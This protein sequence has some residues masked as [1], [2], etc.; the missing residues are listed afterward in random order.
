MR[1]IGATGES[2]SGRQD[3]KPAPGW[4]LGG[5]AEWKSS[6]FQGSNGFGKWG[7]LGENVV[8]PTPWGLDEFKRLSSQTSLQV[9]SESPAQA[10][11]D[12]K[13]SPQ[14]QTLLKQRL[15][16]TNSKE[17]ALLSTILQPARAGAKYALFGPF[18]TFPVP[19]THPRPQDAS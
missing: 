6:I 18:H 14:G 11:N 2:I 12:P 16:N 19:R 9:N 3:A 13:S 5:H 15:K 10:P 7:P 17:L 8:V 4:A 1:Q